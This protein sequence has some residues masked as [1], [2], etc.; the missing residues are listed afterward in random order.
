MAPRYNYV[1]LFDA[2]GHKLPPPPKFHGQLSVCSHA[3]RY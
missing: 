3:T 1:Y 2:L